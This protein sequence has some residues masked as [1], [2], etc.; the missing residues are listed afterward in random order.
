MAQFYTYNKNGKRVILTEYSE[1]GYNVTREDG[2]VLWSV[3]CEAEGDQMGDHYTAKGRWLIDS[4]RNVYRNLKAKTPMF[5]ATYKPVHV[6]SD[7][8]LAYTS[9]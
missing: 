3:S 8:T 6:G 7:I 2:E 9:I 4:K 5:S 1:S